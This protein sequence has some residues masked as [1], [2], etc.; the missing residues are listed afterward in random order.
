MITKFSVSFDEKMKE[1]LSQGHV[2]CNSPQVERAIAFVHRIVLSQVKLS[3]TQTPQ[4][5]LPELNRDN[6]D[7]LK[8][9][10]EN[11]RI[12]GSDRRRD[13]VRR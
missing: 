9:T 8:T 7:T 4:R 10:R 13:K 6:G 1:A 2:F 12:G 3:A 11:V 5:I